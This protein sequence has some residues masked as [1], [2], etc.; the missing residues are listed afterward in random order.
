MLDARKRLIALR[1]L[2]GLVIAS[3]L[4]IGSAIM[5]MGEPGIRAVAKMYG[6]AEIKLTPQ[7]TYIIK[8]LG[9][10]M[11]AFGVMA[12]FAFRD[13]GGNRAVIYGVAG[14]LVLRVLQ[15][16]VF[17]PEIRE[18]FGLGWTQLLLQSAFFAAIAA[19]LVWLCPRPADAQ[20][21]PPIHP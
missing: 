7:F 3:H 2:L 15:R 11:I 10:Y 16:F 17:A 4:L 5:L 12:A 14:L 8:P 13:P 9:A 18:A 1:C 20:S 6:A 19:G 21:D